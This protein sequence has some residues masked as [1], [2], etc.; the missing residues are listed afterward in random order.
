[1]K[2][3]QFVVWFTHCNSSSA[4]A[5]ADEVYQVPD[6]AALVTSTDDQKDVENT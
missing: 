3:Y 6:F 5:A 1:M 4:A 2:L